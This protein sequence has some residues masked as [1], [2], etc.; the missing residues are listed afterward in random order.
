MFKGF[1]NRMY[2]GNPNRPDIDPEDMPKNRFEL[3]FTT[4]G[5]RI[6]DLV[7]LNLLFIV[8]I[9]PILLWTIISFMKLN[10]EMTALLTP[11]LQSDM[12]VMMPVLMQNLAE[13]L[14]ILV[15]CLIIAG[16]PIAG[17]TYITRN[18]ARDEHVWLWGDFKDQM[19]KNWKQSMLVMLILGLVLFLTFITLQVYDAAIKNQPWMWT[20]EILF[21]IFVGMFILSYMYIFPMLVTYKLKIGQ[22]L[23]NSLMLALGRLPFTLMFGFMTIFPILLAVAAVLLMLPMQYILIA[24]VAYYLLFGF[25]FSAFI[26]NS[27]TNATFEKL[28][29]T[30]DDVPPPDD[31]DREVMP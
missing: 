25:A 15:P 22:I 21:I 9:L 3:F 23:K 10:I 26:L 28:L 8:M 11:N 18:Y 24:L 17:M 29:R 14:I 13:Y 16:P 31:N 27:Y 19:K 6:G 1:F 7:K 30:E 5:L 20:M 12:S 2:N 4:L